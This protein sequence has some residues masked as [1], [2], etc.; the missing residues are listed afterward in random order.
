MGGAASQPRPTSFLSML[1]ERGGYLPKE[2]LHSR[3]GSLSRIPHSFFFFF[4]HIAYEV[5]VP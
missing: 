5:L 4:N 1:W 2:H 3:K